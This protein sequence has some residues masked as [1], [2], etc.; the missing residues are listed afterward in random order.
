MVA[1][2]ANKLFIRDTT[3]AFPDLMYKWRES[4]KPYICLDGAY[5]PPF[6][7]I[8]LTMLNWSSQVK[9]LWKH[10]ATDGKNNFRQMISLVNL[11]F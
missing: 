7:A 2:W 6:A 4:I 9:L 11:A 3:I 10:T 1:K 5:I 8:P